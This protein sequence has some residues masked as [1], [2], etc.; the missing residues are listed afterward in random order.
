M[1]THGWSGAPPATDEEA[2]RRIIDATHRCVR[3]VG[4]RTTLAVVA[5]ELGVSRATVYRYFPSTA[6]LLIAAA[7]D[8]TRRFIERLGVRLRGVDDLSEAIIEGVV[9]TV[10][11]VSDEPY[12]QLLLDE[13]SHT[14]LRS[15]TSS[16]A[17]EIAQSVLTEGGWSEVTVADEVFDELIEWALRVVQSFLSD[18]GDPPRDAEQLRAYLHRW[19]APAIQARTGRPGVGTPT[20]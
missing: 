5:T 13:P 4:S 6:A 20:R 12:L 17:R 2:V 11:Q 19:L 9:H 1:R 15:V 16:A 14:L 7:E 3:R 8:G 18:R 10:T